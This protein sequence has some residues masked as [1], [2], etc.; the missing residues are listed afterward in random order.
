LCGVVTKLLFAGFCSRC[1]LKA[2]RLDPDFHTA[3][4]L[5]AFIRGTPTGGARTSAC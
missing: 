1:Y 3:G 2:A 4:I 5:P